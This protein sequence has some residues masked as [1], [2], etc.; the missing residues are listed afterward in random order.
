[1]SGRVK[2]TH[3]FKAKPKAAEMADSGRPQCQA[4]VVTVDVDV[5]MSFSG[6]S[7]TTTPTSAIPVM[8]SVP[9][10]VD[11]GAITP[12]PVSDDYDEACIIDIV[13]VCKATP[14]PTTAS[15][16]SA[17]PRPR[18]SPSP[19]ETTA[20][21]SASG[22]ATSSSVAVT[23]TSPIGTQPT[24]KRA[25]IARAQPKF[26]QSWLGIFPWVTRDEKRDTSFAVLVKCRMRGSSAKKKHY[27]SMRKVIGIKLMCRQ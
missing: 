13:S 26:Q 21:V 5:D 12:D 15:T 25:E 19:R 18:A 22:S 4:S 16:A 3:F 10:P 7:T 27:K 24:A 2:L 14:T 8:C 17:R 23:V 1:M 6:Q 9:P 11:E 20:T